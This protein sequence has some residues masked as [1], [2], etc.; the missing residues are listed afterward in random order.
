MHRALFSRQDPAA[1]DSAPTTPMRILLDDIIFS[2][3]RAGGISS[4]WCE[5]AN[6]LE[7][8]GH[9]LLCIEAGKSTEN[10]FRKQRS[11]IATTFQREHLP[12]RLA[13]YMPCPV[14]GLTASIFHSSYYRTPSRRI[15]PVVQTVHDF[16]Y[17]RYWTGLARTV[18][19]LQKRRALRDADAIICVSESTRRDLEVYCPGIDPDRVHVIH[20]GCSPLFRRIEDPS[21]AAN[22]RALIGDAPYVLYVGTRC[23]YKNF[24]TAVETAAHSGQ[25]RLVLVGGGPLTRAEAQLLEA[26]LPNRWRHEQ[27]P[28]PE[29]LNGLYN[30]ADALLYP[31][32]YEGFGMPVLEAMAA[33]CPV[34][35]VAASSIPEVAGEAALMIPT[36]D[37]NLMLGALKSLG[38]VSLRHDIVRKGLENVRRF[39]WQD[40]VRK[41]ETVYRQ[42]AGTR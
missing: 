5:L 23:A 42:L 4:Y 2:L 38:S 34:I 18:H 36:A 10:L 25:H 33:G 39:S 8:R 11:G 9:E 26:M 15:A 3:Q 6:G 24:P 17:E 28:S 40:C 27:G 14:K 13:R 1:N 21:D 30:L 35:A 19:V 7:A 22:L 29:F 12:W 37:W 16:T 31:S 20:H 32:S 41:T